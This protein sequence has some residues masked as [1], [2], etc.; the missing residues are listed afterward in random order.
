MA[1]AAV[2]KCRLR[3]RTRR[4]GAADRL[5]L[6]E[7]SR[8]VV[9]QQPRQR[10]VGE[11]APAG[12][13]GR[14]VVALVRPR[15]RCAAPARRR[16]GTARRSGRAPPSPA[17]TRSPS[18]ETRRRP[19]ARRRSV[20]RAS[21]VA[22]R[23]VQPRDLL[24]VEIAASAERRQ[25]RRVQDLV[26]VGVAD[27]AEQVRIGQRALER[28]ALAGERCAKLVEREP[29]SGSSPP[30]SSA[31]QPRLPP[32]QPESTRGASSPPSVKSRCRPRSR[33]P[34]AR[35]RAARPLPAAASA[36]GPRSSDG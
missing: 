18:P 8:P 6:V 16:P 3:R 25:P 26:R 32:H 21:V 11:Q 19:R 27:A 34:R 23:V 29:S 28:V 10:A 31:A 20:Q 33:T 7:R 24:V 5:Q 9:V 15:R 36:A 4:P 12:L 17:G 13:A 22:R 14:A 30:G 1:R 2:S 35:G